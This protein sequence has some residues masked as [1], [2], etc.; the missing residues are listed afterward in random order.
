MLRCKIVQFISQVPGRTDTQISDCVYVGTDIKQS[1]TSISEATVEPYDGFWII[2]SEKLVA[3][4]C[5]II[6][7]Y[8]R[9]PS[10]P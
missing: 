5:S 2:Q 8:V 1:Q 3:T 7:S 6:Y 9:S 10:Q 4:G